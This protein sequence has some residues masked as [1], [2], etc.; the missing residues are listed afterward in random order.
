[1][2][3]PLFFVLSLA[4]NA[5]MLFS[6]GNE[7]DS[8]IYGP[9][10]SNKQYAVSPMT[11]TGVPGET[12]TPSLTEMMGIKRSNYDLGTNPDHIVI[13]SSNTSVAVVGDAGAV[14]LKAPGECKINFKDAK[15]RQI[16]CISVTV[17]KEIVFPSSE[18]WNRNELSEGLVYYT[19]K[20]E[21]DK[22]SDQLAYDSITDAYQVV[23]VVSLDLNNSRYQFKFHY[24]RDTTSRVLATTKQAV[25]TMNATY[26]QASI[27]AR[28]DNKDCC[29]MKNNTIS[30]TGVPNWKNEGCVTTDGQRLVNFVYNDAYAKD[31][32]P[33]DVQ[34]QRD[35]I[36]NIQ[37][38]NI[39]S[40][41]PVLIRD[42]EPLGSSYIIRMGY[43]GKQSISS[44]NSEHP[45]NHQGVRHPRSVVALTADNRLLLFTVDGRTNYSSGM[46]ADEITRFLVKHFDPK[47]ALNMDGG[48]STTMCVLGYGQTDTNVVNYPTDNGGHDHFGQR[49]VPTHFIIIDTTK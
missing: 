15:D 2:K 41:A 33:E 8:G 38:P 11:Y 21:K 46:N 45:I 28:V 43:D 35:F 48:G 18:C 10:E 42:Y 17:N 9:V 23:N 44:Y 3:H 37:S 12:F 36:T 27:F 30:S 26:E 19:F 25:V 22:S 16:A 49:T 7:Y 24:G 1:M 20:G 14:T 4:L 31:P 32:T 40:S 13:S 39:F 47:F 6:C 29:T 5:M 34:K